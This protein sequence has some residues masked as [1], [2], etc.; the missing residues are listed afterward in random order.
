MFTP[1]RYL[2][3]TLTLIRMFG[4]TN[5][6]TIWVSE[7]RA[8]LGFLGILSHI[9]S[10]QFYSV[11]LLNRFL[12]TSFIDNYLH[13]CWFLITLHKYDIINSFS[14][15]IIVQKNPSIFQ[16]FLSDPILVPEMWYQTRATQPPSPEIISWLPSD[17]CTQHSTTNWK[18]WQLECAMIA[19]C[20]QPSHGLCMGWNFSLCSQFQLCSQ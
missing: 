9:K 15:V 7:V 13:L 19:T 18:F 8:C 12:I 1:C 20:H 5:Q 14:F 6:L 3:W 17:C 11:W 16:D 2:V 4:L 10:I